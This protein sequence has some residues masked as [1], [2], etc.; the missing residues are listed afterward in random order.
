MDSR[1]GGRRA[2]SRDLVRYGSDADQAVAALYHEHYGS[3]ARIAALL[4]GDSAAAE[5]TVQ[6]AFA[7]VY[8]AWRHLGDGES[9]L[10]YLRRAVL[11]Q[12][13]SRTAAVPGPPVSLLAALRELPARQRE[14]LILTYY[15]DWAHHQIAAAMGISGRA[16]NGHLRRG[17]SALA[18]RA[19]SPRDGT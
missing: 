4:I 2:I 13:R 8:G 16:L 9:A 6:D 19:A 3:L 7:S 12:A 18:G 5:E 11:S 15:A 1:P 14:A 17:L 10:D